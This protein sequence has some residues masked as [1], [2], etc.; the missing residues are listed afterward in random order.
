MDIAGGA[1]WGAVSAGSFGFFPMV[2]FWSFRRGVG[3]LRGCAIESP[4]LLKKSPMGLPATAECPP[5]KNAVTDKIKMALLIVNSICGLHSA[6]AQ[7]PVQSLC[8]RFSSEIRQPRPRRHCLGR[9]PANPF[10][11]ER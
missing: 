7:H 4:S 8:C 1:S 11:V 10:G 3:V 5:A 9:R 6:R 2:L